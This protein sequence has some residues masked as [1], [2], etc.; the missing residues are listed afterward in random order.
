MKDY[1]DIIELSRPVSRSHLPMS[2]SD[3]AAQFS[4]FA[5]LVGYDDCIEEAARLTD[6]F[7]EADESEREDLDR[8]LR[9]IILKNG[10]HPAVKVKWFS[11]DEKKAGG[12]Y[13][14][15]SGILKNIDQV[16]ESLIFTDGTEIYLW[17]ISDIKEMETHE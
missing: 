12:K 11:E 8:K 17:Q 4:P 10:E 14:T 1:E 9:E 16:N 13:L 2:M 3:R 15:S 5:A 7:R 6:D